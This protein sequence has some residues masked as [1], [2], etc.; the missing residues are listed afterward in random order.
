MSVEKNI[1]R[2]KVIVQN[3]NKAIRERRNTRISD[4][5]EHKMIKGYTRDEATKMAQA[6]IDNQ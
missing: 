2:A 4:Y 1:K 3:E 5:I 6:L